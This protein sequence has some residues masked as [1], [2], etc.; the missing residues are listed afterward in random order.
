MRRGARSTRPKRWFETAITLTGWLWVTAVTLQV[1]ASAI[2]WLIGWHKFDVYVLGLLPTTTPLEVIRVGLTVTVLSAVLF[3][4]WA[5]Y[6]RRRFGQ[7]RRRRP[8]VPVSDVELAERLHLSVGE[9]ARWQVE[10]IVEWP[11]DR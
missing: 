1:L 10:K 6:N 3:V 11:A 2:L 8:P 4:G 9:I 7:L 5:T